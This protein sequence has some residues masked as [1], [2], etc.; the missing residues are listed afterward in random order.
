MKGI[1]SVAALIVCAFS[2]NAQ[3]NAR[4]EPL[5]D[6]STL[7][8]ITNDTAVDLTAFAISVNETNG[9]IE[10]GRLIVFADAARLMRSRPC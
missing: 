3:V 6:G 2:L 4:L 9:V 5:S 8:R 7:I 10:G 1:A